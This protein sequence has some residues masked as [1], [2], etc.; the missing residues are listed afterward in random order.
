MNRNIWSK[1]TLLAVLLIAFGLRAGSLTAQSM[2][3]DEIDAIRFSQTSPQTLIGYFTQPGWNGPLFYV[4]LRPWLAVAGSGEFGAR[5]FSL[6]FGVLGV[7]LI[8]RLG[9]A[10][11]SPEVGGLAALWMTFSPYMVW[12]SQEL[13]MYALICTLVL[14]LFLLYDRAL[15]RS[16]WLLWAAVIALAW[17]TM[18]TH[19]VAAL[20]LPTLAL[21]LVIRPVARA[22]LK[23]GL[24]A[25]GAMA[26]PGLI[27]LPWIAPLLIKGYA[28]G[29]RFVPL[30]TMVW[31]LLQAFSRG[32]T[33]AGSIWPMG[34]AVFGLLAG[35]LLWPKHQESSQNGTPSIREA[36]R[37]FGLWIW[38]AIPIL[39]LYLISLRVPIFV[40]RYL[41]WIGPSM[42]L[43]A[44]RGAAQLWPRS[45]PWTSL[46]LVASFAFFILGLWTQTTVPIKSDFRAAAAYVRAN[47]QPDDLVMFH[48]SYV[49]ETFEYYYGPA[50]PFADGIPTN[51]RTQESNI[52]A[53]MRKRT[54]GRDTVWLVLSEPEM[55]D[56]R[57]MTVDW[58]SKHAQAQHRA[59]FARVAVIEYQ[60]EQNLP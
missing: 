19:I 48:I 46:F 36:W 47:R 41:I 51:E 8:Y 23:A 32:V 3:R 53:E 25:L 5:F 27:A 58:F 57:G 52:D 7:A 31:I 55:W 21:W 20:V 29:H 17:V 4:L 43:L 59:D 11:F 34:V 39:S 26:T 56:Q 44:A 10:W 2:W 13:K 16:S 30:N 18:G 45:R 54:A 28:S 15:E 12:Y 6:W 1:I 37:V 50:A 49:R 35:T 14:A 38:L 22:R 33:G 40:D 24:I 60:I 42:Y 9:Q